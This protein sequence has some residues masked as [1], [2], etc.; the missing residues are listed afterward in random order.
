[1]S[2][3]RAIELMRQH[4]VETPEGLVKLAPGAL[5][6]PTADRYLRAWGYDHV[7]LT[8][9]PAAVRI[10]ARRSNELWQFDMSPSD[11]KQVKQLL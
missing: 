2:T 11:L 6:R 9:A 10:Q 5:T 7:R 3:A 8:R 4:D 1:V